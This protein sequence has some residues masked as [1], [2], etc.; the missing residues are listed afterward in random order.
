MVVTVGLLELDGLKLS[1][2]Y[3]DE[4]VL[5]DDAAGSLVVVIL[6]MIEG[7]GAADPLALITQQRLGSQARLGHAQGV[8]LR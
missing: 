7:D 6:G 3:D 2:E 1:P 8:L 4:G 5:V